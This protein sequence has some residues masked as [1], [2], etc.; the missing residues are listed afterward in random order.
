MKQFFCLLCNVI[1]VT[2]H[3]YCRKEIVS[4]I[5]SND[6][7]CEKAYE[8][9]FMTRRIEK[10]SSFTRDKCRNC[11]NIGFQQYHRYVNKAIIC[12]HDMLQ[13]FKLISDTCWRWKTR[14]FLFF[15]PQDISDKYENTVDSHDWVSSYAGWWWKNKTLHRI[16]T[17]MNRKQSNFWNWDGRK[18]YSLI[19]KSLLC[20]YSNSNTLEVCVWIVDW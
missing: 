4:W 9:Y 6:F 10:S 19:K 8:L 2:F 14:K 7:N 17:W 5:E 3:S 16:S 20:V 1:H 18:M 13:E 15:S 12:H 11:H